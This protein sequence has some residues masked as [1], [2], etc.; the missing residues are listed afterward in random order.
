MLEKEQI[1]EIIYKAIE[2]LNE[3]NHQHQLE[4]S[5]NVIL[6]GKGSQLDSIGF[7]SLISYIE[8]YIEEEADIVVTLV[9]EKSIAIEPSPFRTIDTLTKY[10]LSCL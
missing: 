4:K 6:L 5:D 10:I 3:E 1:L 7:V 2:D 9:N 8:D